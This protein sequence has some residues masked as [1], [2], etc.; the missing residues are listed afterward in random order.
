MHLLRVLQL[1]CNR[2]LYF[3][4]WGIIQMFISGS[5]RF[6]VWSDI[7]F[8]N[9][10]RVSRLDNTDMGANKNL[11]YDIASDQKSEFHL[12]SF[13]PKTSQTSHLSLSY[14]N[15]ALQSLSTHSISLVPRTLIVCL[16]HIKLIVIN[17]ALA[18]NAVVWQ[19]FDA[20][21]AQ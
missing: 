4:K 1:W 20:I 18:I 11:H 9:T 5:H 15:F 16:L 17:Q 10:L 21:Y 3:F 19:R 12:F 7:I 8:N 2:R 14:H 6:T 13:I